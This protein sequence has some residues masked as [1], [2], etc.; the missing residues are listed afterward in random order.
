MGTCCP[1]NM[2][3]LLGCV[4]LKHPRYVSTTLLLSDQNVFDFVQT[5]RPNLFYLTQIMPRVIL[6]SL[7]SKTFE[8]G[9]L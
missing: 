7:D 6:G 3:V 9:F 4:Q 5:A 8:I 2:K 1:W